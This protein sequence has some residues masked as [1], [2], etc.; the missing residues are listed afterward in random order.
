MTPGQHGLIEWVPLPL[1]LTAAQFAQPWLDGTP[2]L[3]PSNWPQAG[4]AT[5]GTDLVDGLAVQS[6]GLH[7]PDI[8]PPLTLADYPSGSA[9]VAVA[10]AVAVRR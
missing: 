1:P 4:T 6:G 8:P 10:V 9:A 3:H 7:I 2:N 5:A